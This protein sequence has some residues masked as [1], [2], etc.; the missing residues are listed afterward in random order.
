MK[1]P[2]ARGRMTAELRAP[3]ETRK[4]TMRPIASIKWKCKVENRFGISNRSLIYQPIQRLFFFQPI[5]AVV[6]FSPVFVG[7]FCYRDW[8]H[9]LPFDWLQ[10]HFQN[11]YRTYRRRQ[12]KRAYA[13]ISDRFVDVKSAWIS[14]YPKSIQIETVCARQRRRRRWRIF[15]KYIQFI[16]RHWLRVNLKWKFDSKQITSL[17]AMYHRITVCIGKWI[18]SLGLLCACLSALSIAIICRTFIVCAHRS[19]R[20]RIQSQWINRT[21]GQKEIKRPLNQ[22]LPA[23]ATNTQQ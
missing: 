12:P 7:L 15:A 22:R 14:K 4:K 21:R 2:H 18:E 1:L 13:G 17:T 20:T 11:R 3:R 16:H 19:H 23:N 9:L 6:F 10:S 8:A 5:F